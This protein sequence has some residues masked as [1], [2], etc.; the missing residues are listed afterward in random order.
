MQAPTIVTHKCSRDW[1][2]AGVGVTAPGNVSNYSHIKSS[3]FWVWSAAGAGPTQSENRARWDAALVAA[4]G[5]LAHSSCSRAVLV[6]SLRCSWRCALLAHPLA[7]PW[8]ASASA[9]F[10]A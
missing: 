5:R 1:L 4:M 8:T 3:V 10:A 2:R 6:G 7:H 9:G